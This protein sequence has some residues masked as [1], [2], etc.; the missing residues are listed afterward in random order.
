MV[1]RCCKQEVFI[2]VDYY[3]CSRCHFPCDIVQERPHKEM[4]NEFR[5]ENEAESAFN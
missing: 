5:H 3:T 4:F 2:L 1:S